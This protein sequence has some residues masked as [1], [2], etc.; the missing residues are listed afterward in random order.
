[1]LH[2]P[3]TPVPLEAFGFTCPHA[4]KVTTILKHGG[5][6]LV[7]EVRPTPSWRG[8][9]AL[10]A[11]YHYQDRYGTEIIYLEGK[12]IPIGVS[13]EKEFFT[14]FPIPR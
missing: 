3:A 4:A 5:F 12:E 13:Y 14:R 9:P 11:Q 10:P 1:M 2:P 7:F 8:V 6:S